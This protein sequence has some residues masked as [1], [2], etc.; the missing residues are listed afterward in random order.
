MSLIGTVSAGLS[1]CPQ[2]LAFQLSN[3]FQSG[4][5]TFSY[6]ACT[7]DSTTGVC[8]AGIANFNTNDGSAWNVIQIYHGITGGKDEFTKYDSVLQS[9]AKTNTGG[10]SSDKLKGFCDAWRT[11]ANRMSFQSSQGSVFTDKYFDPSQTMADKL[12]LTLS[13]SQ[14]QLYDAAISHGVSSKKS[15]LAGMIDTTNGNITKDIS[16]VSGSML[17][18]NGYKV[19]EIKWLQLFLKVRSS[20]SSAPGAQASI[21]SYT[22]MIKNMVATYTNSDKKDRGVFQWSDSI[23]IL[24]NSGQSSEVN[25]ANSYAVYPF[26]DPVGVPPGSERPTGTATVSRLRPSPIKPGMPPKTDT[27]TEPETVPCTESTTGNWWDFGEVVCGTA[28]AAIGVGLAAIL[29]AFALAA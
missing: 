27:E 22:Y 13:I 12:G 28:P 25:C 11:A 4:Y 7:T 15:G 18:I 6:G 19:D 5:I 9:N 10:G 1:G 21:D 20:Y 3:V 24:D 26:P 2:N 29:F 14:A 23:A 17:E 16:G 8:R